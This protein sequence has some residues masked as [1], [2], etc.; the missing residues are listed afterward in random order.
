[1][2]IKIEN[3]VSDKGK[4]YTVLLIELVPGYEKSVF[5]D[6]AEVM[7]LQQNKNTNK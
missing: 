4:Q 3:K 2:N 5:L 6:K 1:M 7:L